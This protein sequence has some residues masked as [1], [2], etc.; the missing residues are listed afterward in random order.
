M[1]VYNSTGFIESS[2]YLRPS[3]GYRISL[4]IEANFGWSD[5]LV[6]RR[7]RDLRP[8]IIQESSRG[9]IVS[10]DRLNELKNI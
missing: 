1:F 4:S 3:F 7:N 9:L 10:K 5:P 2:E 8:T 6:V